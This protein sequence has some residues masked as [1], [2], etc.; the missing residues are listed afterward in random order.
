ME[1][2]TNTTCVQNQLLEFTTKYIRAYFGFSSAYMMYIIDNEPYYNLE[3]L[4]L[5]TYAGKCLDFGNGDDFTK[6][7]R[8]AED[9]NTIVVEDC[10]GERVRL[11]NI[12]GLMN[13]LLYAGLNTY[14][15]DMVDDYDAF[16]H[17]CY[18]PDLVHEGEAKVAHYVVN[19]HQTLPD[20][21]KDFIE[22]FIF[23]PADELTSAT[24]FDNI[25]VRVYDLLDV[26]GYNEKIPND[27]LQCDIFS[28]IQDAKNHKIEFVISLNKA[29]KLRNKLGISIENWV[30]IWRKIVNC[31]KIREKNYGY[32]TV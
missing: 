14:Y 26:M 15:E 25:C 11:V 7:Y 23:N 24:M 9:V 30:P 12:I 6:I 27:V 13:V 16:V 10:Y 3:D 5:E 17:G 29:S 20:E 2:L 8:Y 18:K 1:T 21:D 31:Y 19:T 32:Q 28:I 22:F 4:S